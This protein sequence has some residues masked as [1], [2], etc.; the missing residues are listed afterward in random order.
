MKKEGEIFQDEQE[1]EGTT[2][3]ARYIL[4]SLSDAAAFLVEKSEVFLSE[5]VFALVGFF[6]RLPSSLQM[7]YLGDMNNN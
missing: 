3:L 1:E 2:N 6:R 7:K 4:F 5:I